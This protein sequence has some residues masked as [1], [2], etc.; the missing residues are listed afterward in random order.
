M[1][2]LLFSSDLYETTSLRVPTCSEHLV[3]YS[4]PLK[5]VLSE[6]HIVNLF[7]SILV[8]TKCDN[9]FSPFAAIKS[10]ISCN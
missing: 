4:K 8:L 3:L 6:G 9:W 2:V 7:L 1:S 5:L 10:I